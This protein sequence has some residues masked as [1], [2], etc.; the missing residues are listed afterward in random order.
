VE[1]Y[2]TEEE[3]VEALRRWWQENGRAVVAGVVIALAASF[4][5]QYWQG[6]D[7]ERRESASVAYQQMLDSIGA[8]QQDPARRAAAAQQAG[9]LKTDY[10]GT[11]Y[12]NFA[13]LHLARMAVEDGNLTA[14]ED[15]LRWVLAQGPAE[16]VRRVAELRLARVVAAQGDTEAA[17][18][19]LAV[20]ASA[21]YAASFARAEGDILLAAGRADEARQAYARAQGL[22]QQSGAGVSLPSLEQKLEHLSPVPPQ[23]AVDAASSA[24]DGG[25]PDA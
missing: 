19:I 15:E 24:A 16:D 12:G 13:A 4:G 9:Q 10:A 20:D 5:W 8:M 6:Y 14:A 23:E 22:V 25:Q 17:L 11:T 7:Q 1:T 3:Q 18:G 2:R 21:E